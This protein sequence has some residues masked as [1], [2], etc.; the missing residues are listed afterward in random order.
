M[1]LLFVLR[2][3][4]F[5][6]QKEWLAKN[7]LLNYTLDLEELRFLAGGYK[8]LSNGYKS[9]DYRNASEILEHL[10]KLLELRMNKG[11]LCI[12]NAPNANNSILK[13]Y[14]DLALK[15]RY[16]LFII[17]FNT[18]NLE[19]VKL[20]NFIIAQQK[21]V[22]IPEH[23]LEAIDYA[24]QKEKIA[25]KFKVI[26]PYEFKEHLYQIRDLSAYKKIHHI[27]DI[28]GC[29]SVLKK[30]INKIKKDEFYVFLGDYID[31]GIE[32]A[33][34]IK[35]LL[36]LKG[37]ENVILLEGNHERH[38]IKWALNQTASSKEFNENTLKDF[39]KEKLTKEDARALY[40]HFKECF[41]YKFEE[42]II[43]CSHGGLNFLPENLAHLSFISSEE[44]IYGVGSY[45]ES[46]YIAQQFCE[47]TPS[48]T[49]ELFGHRN[50]QKLPIQLAS[51]A[52]LLEGKVDAGGFLRVVTL[53]KKGFECK[54]IKND[55]FR[56]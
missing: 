38:L 9:L 47:N 29:F 46:Q 36:K 26:K 43:F 31:R 4:Y 42:K 24:L 17:E 20:K 44:F 34:V 30:A 28:Q 45:D 2:G 3:N 10:F 16:E 50:R 13:E 23:I 55:V 35:W 14:K 54:E 1:R 18:L 40:P 27:G 41:C 21:G 39:K 19:E 11:E 48:N 6:A 32:N 53:S 33:K 12:V 56:K 51:R 37:L 25:K 5:N 52:F 49:Y 7:E 8:M 15:Y 22:F